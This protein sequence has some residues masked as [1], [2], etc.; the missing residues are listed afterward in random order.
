MRGEPPLAESYRAE[1]VRPDAHRAETVPAAPEAAISPEP[2]EPGPS[3]TLEADLP[4]R[5]VRPASLPSLPPLAGAETARPRAR[6][7]PPP[8]PPPPAP[9]AP[10][11][12]PP[13]PPSPSRP[14]PVSTRA[15]LTAAEAAVDAALRDLDDA[16]PT[17]V[18]SSAPRPP[19]RSRA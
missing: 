5:R 7:M 18:V 9:P 1:P 15:T 19:G 12:A 11:P 10:P 13:P 14:P 17:Q 6:T 2:T 3:I 8:S 16:E 4:P